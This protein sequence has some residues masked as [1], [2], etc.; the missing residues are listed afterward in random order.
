MSATHGNGLPPAGPAGFRS[1]VGDMKRDFPTL[2]EFA[3]QAAE[4]KEKKRQA[5]H[6]LKAGR[7][8]SVKAGRSL[9]HAGPSRLEAQHQSL[10]ASPDRSPAKNKMKYQ[11]NDELLEVEKVE[12]QRLLEQEMEEQ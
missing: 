12:R 8:P 9:L 2:G 6:Q 11:S 10:Q 7:M 4:Q 5:H 1:F 3:Q